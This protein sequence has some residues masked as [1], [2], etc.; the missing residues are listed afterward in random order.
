MEG[1]LTRSLSSGE[2][3]VYKLPLEAGDYARLEVLQQGLDVFTVVRAPSGDKI[4]QVDTRTG[5]FSIENVSLVVDETGEYEV[6]VQTSF[7][8][9]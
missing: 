1:P 7:P 4:A 6:E 5:R 8:R 2:I 3:H 9:A